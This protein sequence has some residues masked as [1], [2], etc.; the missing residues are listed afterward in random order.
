MGICW[1][2]LVNDILLFGGH[3]ALTLAAAVL[4]AIITK[5]GSLDVILAS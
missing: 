2:H 3:A 1:Y 4:L 5:Q